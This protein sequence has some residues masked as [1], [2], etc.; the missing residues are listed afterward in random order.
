M[1]NIVVLGAGT[2]GTLI[3]NMLTHH[4]DLT[5]W[6]ITVIDRAK[7]HV[8]QPGLLFI[9]Y[10]IQWLE[11]LYG[12]AHPAIGYKPTRIGLRQLAVSTI[13]TITFMIIWAT[14]G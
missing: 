14:T 8:Y 1:K 6:K 11:T 13:F 5:E 9:P 3:A 12:T 10:A 4:L 7:L 2:G